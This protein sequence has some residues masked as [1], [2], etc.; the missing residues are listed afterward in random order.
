MSSWL[1]DATW[2]GLVFQDVSTHKRWRTR[3]PSYTLLRNLR[4]PESSPVRRFLRLRASHKVKEYLATF[5]EDKQVFWTFES[6]FRSCTRT[7]AQAYT[8]VHKLKTKTLKDL[9]FVYRPHVYALHGQYM[10]KLPQPTPIHM[11]DIIAY[12]NGLGIDQQAH[13]LESK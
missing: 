1:S 6:K 9:P 10:S 7:L 4:G 8:D 2:Q 13:L 3:N 11:D 12:V 5:R